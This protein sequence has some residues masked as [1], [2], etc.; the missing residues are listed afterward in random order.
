MDRPLMGVPPASPLRLAALTLGGVMA[1]A[2]DGEG[3]AVRGHI[4]VVGG[5]WLCCGDTTERGRRLVA[6][7]RD[8]D[9]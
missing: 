1:D 8:G 7:R 9:V 5:C 6:G 2:A 3:M 4:C